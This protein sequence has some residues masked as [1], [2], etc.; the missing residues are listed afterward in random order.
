MTDSQSLV[1]KLQLPVTPINVWWFEERLGNPDNKTPGPIDYS[2]SAILELSSAD[3]DKLI[4]TFFEGTPRHRSRT[5]QD[6]MPGQIKALGSYKT[7]YFN[8]NAIAKSPYTNGSLERIVDTPY[9]IL[10]LGT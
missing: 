6:W 9:V 1:E 4:D 5:A 8:A 7:E 3:I 2:L 10:R